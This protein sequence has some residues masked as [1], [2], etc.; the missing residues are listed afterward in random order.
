MLFYIY[1]ILGYNNFLDKKRISKQDNHI[2]L[3]NTEIVCPFKEPLSILAF[4]NKI[5]N[6][7]IEWLNIHFKVKDTSNVEEYHQNLTKIINIT[8]ELRDRGY[9]TELHSL[10][11]NGK[12][13]IKLPIKDL[14]RF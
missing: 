1:Q 3:S 13:I 14:K 9:L 2:I 4:S 5:K 12:A 8:E 7:N 10:D 11:F 6:T